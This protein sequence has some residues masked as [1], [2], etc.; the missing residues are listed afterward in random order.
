M[1]KLQIVQH[2]G[3]GG[4]TFDERPFVVMNDGAY[5]DLGVVAKPL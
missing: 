5:I 4:L 1:G 3:E 2:D